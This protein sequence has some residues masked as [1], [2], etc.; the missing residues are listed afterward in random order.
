VREDLRIRTQRPLISKRETGR[1]AQ[2]ALK[3]CVEGRERVR[4][5]H[6]TE[7][8]RNINDQEVSATPEELKNAANGSCDP[9]KEQTAWINPNIAPITMRT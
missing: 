1:N 2:D 3:V 4:N 5:P 7:R 9:T 6:I 8:S